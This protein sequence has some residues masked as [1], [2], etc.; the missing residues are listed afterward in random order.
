MHS[1]CNDLRNDRLT[2]DPRENRLLAALPATDWQRWR[3]HLKLVGMDAGASLGHAG[4]A[5]LQV[6]FPTTA[7]VS[8]QH[9]TRGGASAE[10]ATV[11]SEGMV[12]VPVI[13][14][15]G[16][17]PHSAVVRAAGHGF[18]ISSA[19]LEAEFHGSDAVKRLLLLYV[20]AMMTHTAQSALCNRHHSLEQR[21]CRCLLTSLDRSKSA[22]MKLT[23]EGLAGLLGARREGVTE[24]ALRLQRAGIIE[25]NRGV[26][27][28]LDRAALEAL[29]CECYDVVKNECS[30]LLPQAGPM[31][32]AVPSALSRPHAL[33]AAKSCA[34]SA[35][36]TPPQALQTGSLTHFGPRRNARPAMAVGSD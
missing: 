1:L 9:A 23:H 20:Q 28:V 5:P 21:L 14:G 11:G 8:I 26:I 32:A 22:S 6:Y 7:I 31:P 16:S 4:C 33:P 34:V 19:R 24:A 17:S 35:V 2:V 30:R 10:I 25:Y 27:A 36:G 12:G 18:G 15:G 13:M 3:P 29:S